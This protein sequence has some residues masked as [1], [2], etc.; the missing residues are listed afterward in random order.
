MRVNKGKIK[1]FLFLLPAIIILLIF[2]FIPL[3]ETIFL[4]FFEW[5]LLGDLKF[6]GFAN[7]VKLFTSPKNWRILGN[8]F[9]YILI[10]LVLNFFLPYLLA[11]VLEF[12]LP[13]F[14][15]FFKSAFFLPSF[16]S[17]VVGSILLNWILNPIFGPVAKLLEQAGLSLPNWAVTPSLVIVVISLIVS[18]KVFGYHFIVIIAAMEGI[19]KSLIETAKLDNISNF[20]LFKDI[21]LPLSSYAGLYIFI[22]SIVSGLQ[23]VYTPISIL[24][25]G[26]PNSASSNIVYESYKY[27]FDLFDIGMGSAMAVIT[28][29]FFVLILALIFKLSQKVVFYED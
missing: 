24:T 28:V 2:V 29:V 7:Y 18:W 27:S 13:K 9:I 21:V 12:M 20:R 1:A 14:K 17:M 15:E 11:F 6:V 10:L 22:M 3:L 4:S 16:I 8:T 19:N 26:G 23:Y 5:N 25:Q